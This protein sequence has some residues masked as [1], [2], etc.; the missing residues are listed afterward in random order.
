MWVRAA[1]AGKLSNEGES[2][3]MEDVTRGAD[4]FGG[5]CYFNYKLE[6]DSVV[7]NAPETSGVYGLYNAVWI[8]VGEADNIRSRLLEHLANNHPGLDRYRPSGLAFEVVPPEARTQRFQEL[9]QQTEPIC[10][11]N[12]VTARA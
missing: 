12:A 2:S 7:A 10:Q 4:P 6:R 5:N 11:R 3:E 8:Y 9:V 1:S